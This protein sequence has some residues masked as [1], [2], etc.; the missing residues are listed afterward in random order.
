MGSNHPV[1]C[2]SLVSGTL[3]MGQIFG[4]IVIFILPV[5]VLFCD[6]VAINQRIDQIFR[7][8]TL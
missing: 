2:S 5:P 1:Q 8:I 6:S 7:T 3:L 4:F